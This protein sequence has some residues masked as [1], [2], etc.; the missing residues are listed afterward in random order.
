MLKHSK[1]KVII[2]EARDLEDAVSAKYGIEI[3]VDFCY[4]LFGEEYANFSYK[5]YCFDEDEEYDESFWEDEEYN[6]YAWESKEN[7]ET[8]NLINQFLRE[9]FPG[10]VEILVGI[11]W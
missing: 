8:R 7:V 6:E 11:S 10:E 4:L 1:E 5:F 2:V 3:E 9:E